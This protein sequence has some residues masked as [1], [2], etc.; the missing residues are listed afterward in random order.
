MRA[1]LTLT[2]LSLLPLAVV[3]CQRSSAIAVGD[4]TVTLDPNVATVAHATW[5]TETA[6]TGYV[7]FGDSGAYGMQTPLEST[8]STEHSATI[9]GLQP[10]TDYHFAAA[11]DADGERVTGADAAL[12]TGSLPDDLPELTENVAW[13][14]PQAGPFL[15]TSVV[16]PDA[17]YSYAVVLDTHGAVVWYHRV[18]T[19]VSCVRPLLDGSGVYFIKF[20]LHDA[21]ASALEVVR[22]DGTADVIAVPQI[23][24]DAEQLPDGSFAVP[25]TTYQE[26]DG[27]LV[28]GDQ[29]IRV[30]DDASVSVVWDAFEN[31]PVTRNDGWDYISSAGFADWTHVNG[32]VY[33][34]DSD[35]FVISLWNAYEIVAIDASSGAQRWVFGGVDG[36]F[37]L[38]EADGFG[39]QHAPELFAGGV[40]LF[41]NNSVAGGSRLVEYTLNTS[42]MTAS[43][44]WSYTPPTN[45]FTPVLGDVHR[46]SDG[47]ALSSWGYTGRI[48]SID[49][50]GQING[51]IAAPY[52]T[53]IGQV[54]VLSSFY[55]Q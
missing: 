55:G 9:Y 6:T 53:T 8:A 34:G 47:S 51:E 44:A 49:A 46:F 40:R 36:E 31:L 43:L 11:A 27:V 10:D 12:T 38:P 39:P 21:D 7:V 25:R 29:V 19:E 16:S 24:H 54:T 41:D 5:T 14:N 32:L 17:S 26:V 2:L 37:S 4:V 35:S 20:E 52:G 33:D 48:Q 30:Q 50:S 1:V 45:Q 18:D 3:G 15:V 42:G 13:D 23:H 22:W 28:G